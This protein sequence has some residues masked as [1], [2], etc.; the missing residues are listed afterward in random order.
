MSQPKPYSYDFKKLGQK[1]QEIS[2]DYIKTE[3][4]NI[5][6]RWFHADHVD[7][8]VWQDENSNIIKQQISFYG[9]IVEWNLVDG[10]R[11]GMVVEEE[12]QDGSRYTN[13]IIRFDEFANSLATGQAI[14]I[15]EFTEVIK[16]DL[17]K[18]LIHNFHHSPTLDTMSSKDWKKFLL[19][20]KHFL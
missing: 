19:A 1:L 2:A 7:L 12:S 11:T 6:S 3:R 5:R 20:L 18:T 4:Q 15:I 9:L 16:E 13:E 10:V 14:E 8:Y 17:R